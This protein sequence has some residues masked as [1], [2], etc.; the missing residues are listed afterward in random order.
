MTGSGG[1][2]A[3]MHVSFR[4]ATIV[5]PIPV[6]FLQAPLPPPRCA[7]QWTRAARAD[8]H[9]VQRTAVRQQSSAHGSTACSNA[10]SIAGVSMRLVFPP[11]SHWP[12]LSPSSEIRSVRQ[13]Q[14]ALASQAKGGEQG[15]GGSRARGRRNRRCAADSHLHASLVPFPSLPPCLSPCACGQA[16]QSRGQASA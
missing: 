11:P 8:F 5:L 14:Q 3:T 7:E 15:R 2:K 10:V 6:L 13:R 9:P 16:K 1:S 4:D 12:A